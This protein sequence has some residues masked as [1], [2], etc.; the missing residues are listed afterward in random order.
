MVLEALSAIGLAANVI[1]FLDYAHRIL[2]ESQEIF[3]SASGISAQHADFEAIAVSLSALSDKLIAPPAPS[4]IK[5][6]PD[7]DEIHKVAALSRATAHELISCIQ[8]LRRSGGRHRRW[9]SIRQALEGLWN[10]DR[11]DQLVRRLRDMRSQ[12][13]THILAHISKQQTQTLRDLGRLSSSVGLGLNTR[14]DGLKRDLLL[15]QTNEQVTKPRLDEIAK[16]LST[17]KSEAEKLR[18]EHKILA[19]LSF[20]HMNARQS[21]ITEAHGTTF[22]W[23]FTPQCWPKSDRRSSVEFRQWLLHEHGVYWISGKPGSGKSTLMKYLSTSGHTR[24]CLEVWADSSRLAIPAF[25][26]WISGSELQ[27]SEQGLL[28]GLLFEILCVFPDLIPIV[29]PDRWGAS[30]EQNW[31]VPELL[32]AFDRLKDV[33]THSSPSTKICFFIDG[34]DEY[35]GDHFDLIKTVQTVAQLEDVKLC[36]SSRPWNCFEDAFG[37]D[38]RRKL[39]LQDLTKDDIANFAHSKLGESNGSTIFGYNPSTYQR[40]VEEIVWRAEGVFLWVRL[41]IRSLREGMVN[42]D[43]PTLLQERL[44]ELPSDLGEFFKRLIT[45]VDKVYRKRMSATFQVALRAPEPLQLIQ[46]RFLD[47]DDPDSELIPRP[48]GFVQPEDVSRELHD[49]EARAHRQ[50]N[51]RYKGLLEAPKFPEFKNVDFLHR[52]VRD[53]LMEKEM[54]DF[55]ASNCGPS[56]DINTYACKALLAQT[57]VFP[58]SLNGNELDMFMFW[59][60]NIEIERGVN[61]VRLLDDMNRSYH[62]LDARGPVQ[63]QLSSS[64]FVSKAIQA[65]LLSYIDHIATR[66]PSLFRQDNGTSLA[67]SFTPHFSV[68]HPNLVVLQN[69][70]RILRLLLN[71]GATPNQG[72]SGWT[73]FQEFLGI[74]SLRYKQDLSEAVELETLDLRFLT[75]ALPPLLSHGANI[76]QA[77]NG[78]TCWFTTITDYLGLLTRTTTADEREI[79][80]SLTIFFDHG[81]HPNQVLFLN[82]PVKRTMWG[83]LLVA[84]I[85]SQ[86]NHGDSEDFCKELL[87][88]FIRYGA[89]IW[90]RVRLWEE[91]EIDPDRAA[92][93]YSVKGV[94]HDLFEENNR[95]ELESEIKFVSEMT[96]DRYYLKS[97]EPSRK[98]CA[99][100][101]NQYRKKK[102][103]RY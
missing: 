103:W 91:D 84:V 24:Q 2:S 9:A 62:R 14:I 37:R 70:V 96:R 16:S 26:F 42:G 45:S 44:R 87:K 82:R 55:F 50:L 73:V 68:L 98:R 39:Y 21:S 23:I 8:K 5:L 40:L 100:E 66:N 59:A 93:H 49:E 99:N 81:I 83:N 53:Y 10:K 11:I 92:R 88:V 90:L 48:D 51:G 101:T 61:D 56:F 64:T 32:G 29:C 28:R 94:I 13:S 36:V 63:C 7:E 74:Y 65:G 25:Y 6:P 52:T 1:Q 58:S 34:M 3:H 47:E 33:K 4:S 22:K 85:R 20:E 30:R 80:K 71:H 69:A 54:Q 38:P 67:L 31:T 12:L 17:L 27:K 76:N 15:V 79:L 57:R 46:Y 72:T 35:N 18:K 43:N 19:G 97:Q 41:V 78:K 102:R 95:N 75:L 60:R 89:N 77:F 86:T